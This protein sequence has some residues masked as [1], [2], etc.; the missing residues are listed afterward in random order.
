M[1]HPY[2]LL[3]DIHHFIHICIDLIL[4]I[5]RTMPLTCKQFIGSWWL[6]T[7][8]Y[9]DIL[10][11]ALRLIISYHETNLLGYHLWSASV[12]V[13]GNYDRTGA[14]QSL[15]CHFE[16]HFHE[17]WTP[18][19]TGVLWSTVEAFYC[20]VSGSLISLMITLNVISKKGL[21]SG[22]GISDNFYHWYTCNLKLCLEYWKRKSLRLFWLPIR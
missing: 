13:I 14:N 1:S 10:A 6:H 15:P 2:N 17:R 5:F 20:N 16:W 11:Q 22:L 8:E 21:T 9:W 12:N 4:A 19:S 7:H 18:R 3:P